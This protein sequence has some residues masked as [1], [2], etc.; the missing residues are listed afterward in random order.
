[1]KQELLKGGADALALGL[2]DHGRAISPY[3]ATI[4]ILKG[5]TVL[6]SGT[7]TAGAYTP[8]SAVTGEVHQ[9]LTAEWTYVETV[10]GATKK[11]VELFDVVLSKLVPVVSDADII[12]ECPGLAVKTGV[13]YGTVGAGPLA[14][15][16]ID[17]EL[18]G[19]REDYD[20]GLLTFLDGTLDEK[21]FLVT[22]FASSTGT[23]TAAM[24]SAPAEGDHFTLRNT[25]QAYVDQAW[26]DVY[27][28]LIAQCANDPD[29]GIADGGTYPAS[30]RPYL[31]MTPDRLRRPHLM[32][33]LEKIFRDIADDTSGA[34]WARAEYYAKEFESVW[35]GLKLVFASA[36]DDD[37]PIAEKQTAP[38]W[39]FSR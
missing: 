10:G 39:G 30:S 33:A 3:S 8:S 15:A 21:Q 37:D 13:H 19:C 7:A 17:L 28:K 18:V 26:A 31:I 25:F 23:I 2:V 14:S 34:D 27:D 11:K 36:S 1:M 38:Q 16:I 20:G 35:N 32:K 5:S 22:A 6:E 4:R 24:G 9:D 29:G 12:K